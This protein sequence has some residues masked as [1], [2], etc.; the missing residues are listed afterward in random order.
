GYA[1]LSRPPDVRD[2]ASAVNAP[3]A[4]VF[5]RYVTAHPYG[6]GLSGLTPSTLASRAPD[7]RDAAAYASPPSPVDRI[8]AQER[9]RHLDPGLFGSGLSAPTHS[10]LVVRPP[11]VRDVAQAVQTGSGS[12]GQT[13][14]FDWGDS[15]I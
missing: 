8:I 10:T 9:A 4:D 1:L 12:I 3:V 2:T 13:T 15:A 11:D 7:I 6:T 14:S 5:E